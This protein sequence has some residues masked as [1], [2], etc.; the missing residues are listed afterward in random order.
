MGFHEFQSTWNHF[1]YDLL[2]HHKAQ[3]DQSLGRRGL[4]SGL[5][6]PAILPGRGPLFFEPQTSGIT[7]PC[8][9][10]I[11]NLHFWLLYYVPIDRVTHQAFEENVTG[12]SYSRLI[13]TSKAGQGVSPLVHR[14]PGPGSRMGFPTQCYSST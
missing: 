9:P 13:I 7:E 5:F 6:L 3:F 2:Y 4:L 10:Q 14:T 11:T 12:S 1:R 8:L